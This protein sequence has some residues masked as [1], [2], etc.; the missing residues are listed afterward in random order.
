MMKTLIVAGLLMLGLFASGTSVEA[1][2]LPCDVYVTPQ[3][4]YVACCQY[5]LSVAYGGTY[6]CVPGGP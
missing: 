6:L 2:P 3:A 5:G 1:A 4:G